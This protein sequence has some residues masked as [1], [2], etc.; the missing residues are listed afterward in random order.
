MAKIMP[1]NTIMLLAP[2]YFS[3]STAEVAYHNSDRKQQ[4]QKEL[5][6]VVAEAHGRRM[7][8]TGSI[9]SL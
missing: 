7:V 9:L 1:G 6:R 5:T 2:H 4:Q 3:T 8:A